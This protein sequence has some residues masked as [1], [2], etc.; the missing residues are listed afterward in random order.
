[1]KTRIIVG[2]TLLGV[3]VAFFWLDHA[4]EKRALVSGLICLLGLAGWLE[5]ARMGK[6]HSRA[7]GGGGRPLR[8]VVR[9]LRRVRGWP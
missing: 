7:D 8:P 2:T 1:M 9:P 5:L 4:M 3:V 6:I